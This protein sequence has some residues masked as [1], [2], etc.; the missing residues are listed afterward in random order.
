[1]EILHRMVAGVLG[2]VAPAALAFRAHVRL[3][4]VGLRALVAPTTTAAADAPTDAAQ[5]DG[6]TFD[7]V[8]V[9]FETRAA[10]AAMAYLVTART[11]TGA[12]VAIERRKQRGIALLRLVEERLVNLA[13]PVPVVTGEALTAIAR[14]TPID[15]IVMAF[16][17]SRGDVVYTGDVGD[18]DRLRRYFPSV[19]VLRC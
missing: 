3:A 5:A 11:R 10:V 16:A 4:R 8:A 15:A 14:A 7:A 2:F 1:M 6:F 9:T 19:R 12:L 17:A 13:T 18:L